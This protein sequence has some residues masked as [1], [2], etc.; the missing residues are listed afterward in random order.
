VYATVDAVPAAA[1]RE[2]RDGIRLITAEVGRRPPW[3]LSAA[4]TISYAENLAARRW[5][6][7]RGADDVL[8]VSPDGYA[9][10]APTASLIWLWRDTLCTVPP[11]RTGI[12]L[13]L[14][15]AALLGHARKVG[16]TCWASLRP[17][18]LSPVR[19]CFRSG[20]DPGQALIPV[21]L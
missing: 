7:T 5:A 17:E 12:L 18:P 11:Q 16:S 14:T 3:S 6:T 9:L 21:R 8:W 15:A 10:E 20:F 13:G 19:L 1:L 4:K 2:R